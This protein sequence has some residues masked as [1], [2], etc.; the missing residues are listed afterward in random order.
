VHEKLS[1]RIQ[2]FEQGGMEALAAKLGAEFKLRTLEYGAEALAYPIGFPLYHMP[3]LLFT[4]LCVLQQQR[5]RLGGDA[6]SPQATDMDSAMDVLIMIIFIIIW[7]LL[8]HH[9]RC[10]NAARIAERLEHVSLADGAVRD[11]QK[12]LCPSD[13]TEQNGLEQLTGVT[14]LAD[15][16]QRA[17]QAP[18]SAN[19]DSSDAA[20][21]GRAMIRDNIAHRVSGDN[22]D[23]CRRMPESAVERARTVA[24]QAA[25]AALA[26]RFPANNFVDAVNTK[27]RW[28]GE[29]GRC[30][31][32]DCVMQL[33]V[34]GV[35]GGP[36]NSSPNTIS[37]GRMQVRPGHWPANTRFQCWGCNWKQYTRIMCT[38]SA[39]EFLA[40]ELAKPQ[41]QQRKKVEQ[42][43]Q[44]ALARWVRAGR[45]LLDLHR[46]RAAAAVGGDGAPKN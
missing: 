46:E 34:P 16:F 41:R 18:L 9:P 28:V 24:R 4:T 40:V 12:P 19:G 39:A 13:V 21:R 2:E 35:G 6:A 11:E 15:I 3:R 17:A 10:K 42:L 1:T 29:L 27:A 36:S 31:T 43:V 22:D 7:I 30:A 38:W 20:E 23:S 8:V 44:E 14:E 37:F 26:D 5:N 25:A 45:T 33:P 32:C